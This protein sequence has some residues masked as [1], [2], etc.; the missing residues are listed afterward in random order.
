M[1][2][3]IY[4]VAFSFQDGG[5]EP[6]VQVGHLIN[7]WEGQNGSW[8]AGGPHCE[9]SENLRTCKGSFDSRLSS[10]PDWLPL[11]LRGLITHTRPATIQ[12]FYYSLNRHWTKNWICT[13][14]LFANM[15]KICKYWGVKKLI[16]GKD[17]KCHICIPKQRG[18][19]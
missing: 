2:C 12:L 14:L 17:D 11:G 15:S 7:F 1:S 9:K 6:H 18:C 8:R 3:I 13:N 19:K 10:Q 16:Y 5:C 4:V